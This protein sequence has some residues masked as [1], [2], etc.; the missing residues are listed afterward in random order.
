[1]WYSDGPGG[2]YTC[3]HLNKNWIV[4]TTTENL[5][6]LAQPIYALHSYPSPVYQVLNVDQFAFL[7]DILL[8]L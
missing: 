4:C 8:T 5:I 3:D 6:L 2:L 1:M 7:E